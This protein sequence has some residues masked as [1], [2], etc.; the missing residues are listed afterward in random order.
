MQAMRIGVLSDTHIPDRTLSLPDEI[1]DIFAGVDLILHAGDISEALVLERL[2]TV[3]PVYAVRGNRDEELH[4][5]PE[6]RV[7]VAGAWRIGLIHG[8]RSRWQEMPDRMRYLR[9]DHRFLD[10]RSFVLQAFAGDS[11]QCVVFGHSHQACQEVQD[12]VLLLNPGGVVPSP[13]GGPSSVAILEL[14]SAGVRSRLIPLRFPPQ[15]F[16]L[17]EE[18]RRARLPRSAR[19]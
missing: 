10:Q 6:R 11:V 18:M 13:G 16:S 8:L 2:A 9:R 14:D 17:R 7:V 4:D 12:G 19:S 1:L 5:L 15:R 3:A